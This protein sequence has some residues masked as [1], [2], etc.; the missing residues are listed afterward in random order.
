MKMDYIFKTDNNTKQII[1]TL[2]DSV[3][4]RRIHGQLISRPIL[5]SKDYSSSLNAVMTDDALYY[6]YVDI[7][8]S[9]CVRIPS[10]QE[11]V[12]RLDNCEN[13]KYLSPCLTLIN[14]R[15]VLLFCDCV[16]DIKKSGNTVLNG[17][18]SSEN[19]YRIRYV[20]S[21]EKSNNALTS[22]LNI[23]FSSAVQI[24]IIKTC[25]DILLCICCDGEFHLLRFADDFSI[26]SYCP[27]SHSA[28]MTNNA[29]IR[30]TENE[31]ADKDM[32]IE[33]MKNEIANKDM[34][35]EAMKNEI[36]N[37]D[38]CLETTKTELVGRDSQIENIKKELSIRN[39]QIESAKIQYNEL[40]DVATRYK[41]EATKWRMRLASK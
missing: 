31:S 1:Y 22:D 21:P 38:I 15:L 28:L 10:L 34:Q 26:I 4:T 41:D 30:Q 19:K 11:P 27:D 13:H 35:I 17:N 40:M 18:D 25:S 24:S 29:Q 14:K 6:S 9:L 32:L 8:G 16:N 3:L 36:V 37:K 23:N 20:I 2:G 12:F 33:A 7:N 5:L 39:A